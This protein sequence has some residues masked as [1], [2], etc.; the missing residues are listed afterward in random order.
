MTGSELA[1]IIP[2]WNE[3][4]TVAAIVKGAAV[5]GTPVVV[6][7]GS[8]DATGDRAGEAGAVVL[9]H[10]VNRGYDAALCTGLGWSVDGGF[11]IVATIDADAQ[12]DPSIIALLIEPLY[13]GRADAVL[14]TRDRA[15]RASERLFRSYT[16]QRFG[17][18]DPLCGMKAFSTATVAVHRAVLE[19]PSIGTGLTLACVRGGGR[20]VSVAV[21]T[22]PREGPS[23]F[24]A[25]LR[26][27][28]RILRALA[29]AVV[30]DVR[31]AGRFAPAAGHR[32]GMPD[33]AGD[34]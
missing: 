25:G 13:A 19:R 6:D 2:A 5:F 21:P 23:R 30:D 26:A 28:G 33:V 10:P 11:A 7:D 15:P 31:H 24:G 9:R 20:V 3:E 29:G 22:F 34:A 8:T 27:D 17:I 18:P 1:V 4:S 14:G 32:S 16:R 12:H